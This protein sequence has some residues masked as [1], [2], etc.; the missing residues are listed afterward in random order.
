MLKSVTLT[1]LGWFSRPAASASRLKRCTNSGFRANRGATTL[2]ATGRMVPIHLPNYDPALR[3]QVGSSLHS[4][5][6]R[7]PAQV[8]PL[9]NAE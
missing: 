2:M 3:D 8:G 6:A 4:D 9:S 7:W 5:C 1:T